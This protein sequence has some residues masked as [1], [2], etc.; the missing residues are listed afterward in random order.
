M[1]STKTTLYLKFDL[2]TGSTYDL[3]IESPKT[4]GE[5]A[6]ASTTT[7]AEIKTIG[8]RIVTNNIILSNGGKATGLA[9]AYVRTVT[10][11]DVAIVG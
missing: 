4:V 5:T 7:P 6:D 1:A 8:D 2:S 10:D 3:P 11:T 9:S